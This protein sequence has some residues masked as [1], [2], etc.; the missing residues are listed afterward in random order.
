MSRQGSRARRLVRCVRCGQM[1]S[2]DTVQWGSVGWV[3]GSCL[4]SELSRAR[5][6]VPNTGVSD[7]RVGE[8]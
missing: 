5:N 4:A 2:K 7:T 8:D 1:V 3:G 6:E